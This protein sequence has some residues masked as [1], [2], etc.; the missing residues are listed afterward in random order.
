M[1]PSCVRR[2]LATAV[3]IGLWAAPEVQAAG[4]V[5]GVTISPNPAAIQ[6]GGS[7]PVAVIV[8]GE[9]PCDEVEVDYGDKNLQRLPVTRFPV[10]LTHAFSNSGVFRVLVRGTKACSGDAQAQAAIGLQFSGTVSSLAGRL[11]RFDAGCNMVKCQC[12]DPVIDKLVPV[13]LLPRAL[14]DHRSP[15]LWFWRRPQYFPPFPAPGRL[16]E[17]GAPTN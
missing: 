6:A 1:R 13:F 2:L 15:G 9:G 8:S 3:V 17:A 14:R 7:A 5:T 4:R 10:T 12:K 16:Q 11:A